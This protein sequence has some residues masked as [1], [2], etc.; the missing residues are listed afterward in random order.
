MSAQSTATGSASPRTTPAGAEDGAETQVVRVITAVFGVATVVFFGLAL[1]PIFDQAQYV[2]PL[3][4]GLMIGVV[5][6][7]PVIM[8]LAAPL[9]SLAT[10]RTVHAVYSLSYS[11]VLI[12]WVPAMV[13]SPMPLGSSPWPLSVMALGTVPAALAWPAAIAWGVLTANSVLLGL[14]RY[15]AAGGVSID[16]PIQDTLYSLAFAA[17]FTALAL[18]ALRSARVLDRAT[19]IERATASR[20]ASTAARLREQS[21][22][23]AL[24]HDE[25]M[26]SLYYASTGERALDATVRTQ[27]ARALAE[28][29][30]IE[31]GA[32][33]PIT[34]IAQDEFSTRLR[35]TV[36]TLD[37][38]VRFTI[39]GARAS[40]IPSDVV[41][42]LLDATSEAVRNSLIH[43][44]SGPRDVQR[45]VE[46][47]LGEP[48]VMVRIIDN[49]IGFELSAVPPQRLGI[50]LSIRH[51]LSLVVGGV[52]TVE[53]TPGRGTT[54][55]LKW[56]P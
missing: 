56:R 19:G 45:S 41:A 9:L 11:A 4:L 12:A 7:A 2:T 40:S 20:L 50:L 25:V 48:E 5:F 49:G 22:L 54:V 39:A 51:R 29:S 24:V 55:T 26:S 18:V 10:L 15:F 8:A 53:S 21:R 47:T 30:R 17:I 27:A 28:V 38:S 23:D 13:Q 52:G 36:V 33:Q 43:A 3:S 1:G 16:L 32:T 42:A 46:L 34:P 44:Q 14:V 6:G 35:S 37:D 31:A